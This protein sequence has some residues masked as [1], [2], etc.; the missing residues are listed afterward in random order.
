MTYSG[1]IQIKNAATKTSKN[2]TI[3]YFKTAGNRSLMGFRFFARQAS[4]AFMP[5]I[6]NILE[7]QDVHSRTSVIVLTTADQIERLF[8]Y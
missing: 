8:F 3:F 5:F 1:A 6:F 2:N 4:H 7:R